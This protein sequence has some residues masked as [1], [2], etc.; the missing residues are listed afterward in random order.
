MASKVE[1]SKVVIAV[2][3]TGV[4]FIC[5]RADKGFTN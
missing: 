1:A 2:L 5:P 3:I 4:R